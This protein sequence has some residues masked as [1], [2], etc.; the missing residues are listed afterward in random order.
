MVE[1]QNDEMGIHG[2]HW[3]QVTRT[4]KKQKRRS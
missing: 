3:D 2:T 1:H 4:N